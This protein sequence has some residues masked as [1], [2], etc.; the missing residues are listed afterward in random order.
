[1]HIWRGVVGELAINGRELCVYK[2]GETTCGQWYVKTAESFFGVA[3]VAGKGLIRRAWI[4]PPQ[5]L[6]SKG[7]VTPLAHG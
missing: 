4:I 5:V 6:I 7:R 1:M 2:R 3:L